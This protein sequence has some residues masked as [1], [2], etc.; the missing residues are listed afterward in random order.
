MSLINTYKMEIRA[1]IP[2]PLERDEWRFTRYGLLTAAK[3]MTESPNSIITTD[4]KQ[5]AKESEG[6]DLKI[7]VYKIGDVT[8]KS[9]RSCNIQDLENT[10]EMVQV[11][12]VTLVADISMKK[13]EY[14]KN[15]V[16]YLEDLNKKLL[17]IDNEFA[18]AVEQLIYAKLDTEKSIVYNSPLVG[19]TYPL[20]ANTIQ[21]SP[22]QQEYFFNDL[23]AIMEG[24][25]FYS[26]PFKV[27]GSTTLKPAV[28]HWGHQGQSN[29]ENLLY[30]FDGYDFRFSNHITIGSGKK[31][32]GFCMT[33][34][35]L[36]IMTRINVDAE[37][38][39]KASDGTEWGKTYMDRFGFEVGV[40][41]KS[42][43]DDLSGQ[44]GLEHLTASMVEKWQFSIDVALLTPYNSDPN[45]LPGVIKKFEFDLGLN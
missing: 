34:G 23:E 38:G 3:E 12:W 40:M 35:S 32:T 7:P 45:N 41:Y 14:H 39:N 31:A 15:E 44:Q 30:Q 29:D 16:S 6:R 17:R 8:I 36:G 43:C 22:S 24:D 4:L 2:N 28:K 25:D 10:T 1:K 9:T 5:K 20:T 33:D 11:N 18:K 37:M 19:T 42:K 27:L 13:A 26:M 21:V